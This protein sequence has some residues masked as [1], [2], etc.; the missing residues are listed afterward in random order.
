VQ[1]QGIQTK[2]PANLRLIRFRSS[3]YSMN[4]AKSQHPTTTIAI[5]AKLQFMG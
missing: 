3:K 4:S 1:Q 2:G 5:D